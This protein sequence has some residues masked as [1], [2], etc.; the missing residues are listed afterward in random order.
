MRRFTL[1][2]V[3]LGSIA[4]AALLTWIALSSAHFG[5]RG[6]RAD[7]AGARAEATTTR[8]LPPFTRMDVSGTADVVLV[9]GTGEDVTIGTPTGKRAYLTAEVRGDTLYIESGDRT[10]W[11]DW[12]VE[13]DSL[14]TPQ[15]VVT[16]RDLQAI[17]AAGTVKLTAAKIKVTDLKIAAAGGTQVKIDD[18]DARQ[19]RLSGAGALKAEL[20]GR[21]ADQNVSIS[22]AGDYRGA[23]LASQN[24]TVNVA[25]A[26]RVV[27]NAEKTLNATIS[28]AGSVE[29]L[30][31]PQVTEHVSGAGRV[32]RRDASG[33]GFTRI[34]IAE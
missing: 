23:R 22:G 19:L 34:V 32:R 8:P 4:I 5:N 7:S 29:Y 18:L 15:V 31:D 14:R 26:A 33:L 9:Q 30:G 13:G 24:A 11:W 1:P 27:I 10:R 16:F 20:A 21:V 6:S 25:G 28:G 2:L 17:T 3:I 12:L